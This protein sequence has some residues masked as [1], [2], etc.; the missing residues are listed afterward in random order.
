MRQEQTVPVYC[1]QIDADLVDV[2]VFKAGVAKLFQ[3]TQPHHT[4]IP[5]SAHGPA[6]QIGTT[7]LLQW[8][9]KMP[10]VQ[11]FTVVVFA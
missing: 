11:R 4:T 8:T 3:H 7:C 5:T 10:P 9:R 2:G 1:Y 6:N